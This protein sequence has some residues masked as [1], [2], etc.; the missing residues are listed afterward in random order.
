V[1]NWPTEGRFAPGTFDID[2]YP[3]LVAGNVGKAI[4]ARLVDQHPVAD[5]NFLPDPG[6]GIVDA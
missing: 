1:G 4:D 6:F 5:A 2:V 3:L